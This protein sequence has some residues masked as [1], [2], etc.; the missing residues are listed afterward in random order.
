MDR[1]TDVS[2]RTGEETENDQAGGSKQR[3]FW[4]F[5]LSLPGFIT[6]IASLLGALAALAALFVHQNQ[7]L[8]QRTEALE[9]ATSRPQP[10]V[11]VT[12]TVT[13]TPAPP[14]TGP[15]PSALPL[16]DGS[17]FLADLDPV[18]VGFVFYSP[19]TAI[20]SDRPYPHS[21]EVG[22]SDSY[23]IY[24]TGGS[25]Q[26]TAILGVAD[27]AS[28]ANGAIA[29]ISFY[30]QDDRQIGKTVSVSVAHPAPVALDMT[31]VIQTKI[32]CSGRD[33]VTDDSRWFHVMLGDAALIP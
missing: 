19:E 18:D 21:V 4:Q 29:D 15:G 32:T 11:T 26:L 23:M 28:D 5:W 30:D 22:C 9:Q 13:A 31:G 8:T 27:S 24:N 20:M 33:R 14:A 3:R 25:K 2:L 16:A 10:T 6:A 1:N 12:E 7:Q 17:R